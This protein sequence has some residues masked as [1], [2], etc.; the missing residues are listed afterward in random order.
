MGQALTVGGVWL[1]FGMTVFAWS[2]PVSAWSQT[3]SFEN[4]FGGWVPD[5]DVPAGVGWHILRS[6]VR[7]FDGQWSLEYYLDGRHDDGTIWVE[8]TVAATGPT[9]NVHIDFYMWSDRKGGIGGW[10]VVAFAG[11]NNPERETDFHII[12]Y[13]NY[14]VGWLIYTYDT[15]VQ[16]G[17]TSMFWVAFGYSVTFETVRTDY[18]DY[19]TITVT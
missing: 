15:T 19:V 12:G 9:V 17:T 7:A 8:R 18:F 16:I 4:G 13:V 5:A 11:A 14:D 2:V 10:P 3:E 6:N 1:V